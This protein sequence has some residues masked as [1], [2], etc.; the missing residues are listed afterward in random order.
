[1]N[2]EPQPEAFTW[3]GWAARLPMSSFLTPLQNEPSL[4][5]HFA[6]TPPS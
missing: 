3:Y 6:E 4:N 2:S 1:M 5:T